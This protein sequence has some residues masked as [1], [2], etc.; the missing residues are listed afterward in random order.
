MYKE[1][2][3]SIPVFPYFLIKGY[4]AIKVNP[5]IFVEKSIH[6]HFPDQTKNNREENN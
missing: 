1:D 2:I 5:A 3:P 4:T 6:S